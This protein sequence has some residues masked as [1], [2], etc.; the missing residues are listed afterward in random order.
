[1]LLTWNLL[2]VNAN[3]LVC[4][5]QVSLDQCALCL[6]DD[7]KLIKEVISTQVLLVVR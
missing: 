4:G 1:M 5:L 6:S 3:F 2:T 7:R